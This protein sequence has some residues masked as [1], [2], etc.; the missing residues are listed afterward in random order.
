MKRIIVILG[1]SK[2]DSMNRVILL[3]GGNI[4]DRR[5]IL[6]KA[7]HAIDTQIGSIIKASPIIESKAWGF[8]SDQAF[9]NQVLLIETIDIAIE[10]LNKIQLIE[11][12]LGRTRKSTQW[13]SRMI[14]IDILFFN[15]DII[16]TERLTIPHMHIKDR[17][18]T[19]Y[20]L[21]LIL[22]RLKHPVYHKTI[23]EL[24]NTCEDQ[25]EVEVY[26]A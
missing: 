26:F 19:L 22:P 3:T 1:T 15:D 20:G 17:R 11:L 5:S 18:F 16:Q 13:M 14:D 25:S 23:K 6:D 24:L 4:A 10:V 8:D 12:E 21:S 9:L 7:R 2:T